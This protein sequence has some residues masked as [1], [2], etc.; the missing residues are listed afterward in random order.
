[1]HIM[2]SAI[3]AHCKYKKKHIQGQ[4]MSGNSGEDANRKY[5]LSAHDA[6]LE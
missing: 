5:K 1:M 2:D 4:Y 6:F 3:L